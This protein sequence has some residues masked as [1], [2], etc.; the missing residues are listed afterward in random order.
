M[1]A[2]EAET[3]EPSNTTFVGVRYSIQITFR[4]PP[5]AL[6]SMQDAGRA[7][8]WSS[9]KLAVPTLTGSLLW[10]WRNLIALIAARRKWNGHASAPTGT[11]WPTLGGHARSPGAHHSQRSAVSKS[12][13]VGAKTTC[14]EDRQEEDGHAEIFTSFLFL[15]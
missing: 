2:Y 8:R 7:K 10:T 11:T 3:R 14:E 12:A 1:P 4:S 9:G 15:C 6:V 5:S 13:E